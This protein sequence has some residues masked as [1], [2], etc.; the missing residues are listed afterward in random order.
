MQILSPGRKRFT[1]S[2]KAKILRSYH[3]TQLS[4]QTF[5]S[6]A[7]ISVSALQNWLRQSRAAQASNTSTFIAIPNLLA[8]AQKQ[9]FCYR[10][11][12]P[13]DLNLEIAR[14]F[15][16]TEVGELCRLLKNL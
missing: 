9:S 7:G 4:Q 8:P 2:E 15:A 1:A 12:L 10:L 13:G 5:A 14:G 16:P 3:G 6:R 11:Q